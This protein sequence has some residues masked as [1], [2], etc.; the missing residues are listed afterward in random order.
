MTFDDLEQELEIMF[1][2]N[3]RKVSADKLAEMMPNFTAR[4][5]QAY[6]YG[7]RN[8]VDRFKDNF[9]QVLQKKNP[10]RANVLLTRFASRPKDVQEISSSARYLKLQMA[11]D[12]MCISCAG[13]S[14]EDGGYC[15]DK[16]CPLA[17]FTKMPLQHEVPDEG[18]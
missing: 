14:P 4:T 7:H 3:S 12:K 15:W 18:F 16:T 6:V 1:P 11:I 13:D 5:I 10:E 8:I 9:I 2:G 17:A